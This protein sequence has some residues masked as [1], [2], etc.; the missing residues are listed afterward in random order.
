MKNTAGSR[1]RSIKIKDGEQSLD[2]RAALLGAL[3][4]KVRLLRARK[5]IPRRVLA[6]QADVSERHLANLENGNG[7][8]SILVLHQIAQALGCPLVDLV[9]DEMSDSPD[10]R[11]IQDILQGRS[12]DELQRARRVLAEAFISSPSSEE[13]AKRIALI[14]LRGAGK[15]TLGHMLADATERPFVEVGREV[16]RL[17]GVTPDEIQALYGL[18]AYRRYERNALE[19]TVRSYNDCIIATPGGIV[20]DA[21][22][23]N[24]LLTNC[25]TVWLQATPDEHMARVIE[26]G[27]MRPIAASAE[28]MEDLKM[29]LAG[30]S[31]FYAKADLAYNTSGKSLAESFSGLIESLAP[32]IA[33]QG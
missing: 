17:A 5:G 27:D 6:E 12:S 13:R 28:A 32:V 21:A 20:S 10:W 16:T 15:S 11:M 19:E 7:N 1:K 24:F 8:V 25:Y 3:G 22:T 26:Q 29:I 14:G 2:P 23:F 30:R 31:A 9:G 33:G 18:N 4:Q